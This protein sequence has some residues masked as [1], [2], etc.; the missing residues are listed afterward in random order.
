MHECSL[1][2]KFH[3]KTYFLF[4]F[5]SCKFLVTVSCLVFCIQVYYIYIFFFKFTMS[6]FHVYNKCYY[7]IYLVIYI[8]I[9]TSWSCF[10]A[11][12]NLLVPAVDF[13]FF[14]QCTYW[15]QSFIVTT[16][17]LVIQSYFTAFIG[18]A[19]QDNYQKWL[20]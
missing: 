9:F 20:K 8:F 1:G 16:T 17:Y 12:T 13:L 19:S 4:R 11:I 6:I 15:F 10:E 2:C 18:F 7:C 5:L 3:I 14:H